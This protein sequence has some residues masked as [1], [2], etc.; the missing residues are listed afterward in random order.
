[1]VVE[2]DAILKFDYK[3]SIVM[4]SIILKTL[5]WRRNYQSRMGTLTC[6]SMEDTI[7]PVRRYILSRSQI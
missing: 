2:E 1:M 4:S 7:L 3:N 6:T 5:A